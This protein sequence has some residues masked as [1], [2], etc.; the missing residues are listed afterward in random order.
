MKS[1]KGLHDR[2]FIMFSFKKISQEVEM[3]SQ[4][5]THCWR[6]VSFVVPFLAA[7]VLHR[8]AGTVQWRWHRISRRLHSE[9]SHCL[10][11]TLAEDDPHRCWKQNLKWEFDHSHWTFTEWR[12]RI[13]L[14]VE[15]CKHFI[16]G[17]GRNI[18]WVLCWFDY[19]AERFCLQWVRLR[20]GILPER[21]D[22]TSSLYARSISLCNHNHVR[23]V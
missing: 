4:M 16:F 7:D 23:K 9:F 17:C 21:N 1:P 3:N 22:W 6:F 15:I 5:S 10:P 2:I 14:T 18:H 8:K 13:P 20:H 12:T 19:I 11:R